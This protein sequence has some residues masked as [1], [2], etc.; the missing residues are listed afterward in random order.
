MSLFAED[1]SK[2]LGMQMHCKGSVSKDFGSFKQKLLLQFGM[3]VEKHGAH[4]ALPTQV[5][6]LANS[7]VS[8]VTKT[9]AVGKQPFALEEA[10]A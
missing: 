6:P 8:A 7:M 1:A 9:L 2:L 5:L 3:I 4:L 10:D